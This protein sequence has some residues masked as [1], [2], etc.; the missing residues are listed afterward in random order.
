MISLEPLQSP[1]KG[2]L[3]GQFGLP[4]GVPQLF[5]VEEDERVIAHP[6]PLAAGVFD[7]RFEPYQSTRLSRYNAGRG[8]TGT[9]FA[10]RTTKVSEQLSLSEG[11][12]AR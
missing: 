8:R 7:A 2:L 5:R 11:M 9:L 4:A 3:D 10:L 6:P 1:K 12:L